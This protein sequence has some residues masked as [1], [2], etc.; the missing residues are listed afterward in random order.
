MFRQDVANY[1]PS[2][3]FSEGLPVAAKMVQIGGAGTY[4]PRKPNYRWQNSSDSSTV[5]RIFKSFGAGYVKDGT[6]GR[7]VTPENAE[8]YAPLRNPR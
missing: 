4:T 7:Y 5:G 8:W 3:L 1:Y 2:R 6:H